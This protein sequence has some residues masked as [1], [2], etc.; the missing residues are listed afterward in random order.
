MKKTLISIMV[1]LPLSACSPI[2]PNPAE[3]DTVWNDLNLVTGTKCPVTVSTE[4]CQDQGDTVA[5]IR[6][7]SKRAPTSVD[8][9][10]TC[11]TKKVTWKYENDF[12]DGDAPAFFIIFDPK[13]SPG[14]S[15][16]NPISKPKPTPVN[17][18]NQELTINTR[19]LSAGN[20]S[21]CLNYMIV[22]PDKG[23]LD[24][25]FIIRE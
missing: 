25:V 7:D 14:G 12:T 18:S 5:N 17:A 13:V 11:A 2:Q 6:V 24:P 19:S 8:T 20:N 23:I 9:I 15:T 10:Q 16:Y 3:T 1:I 22:V 4:P 21:E